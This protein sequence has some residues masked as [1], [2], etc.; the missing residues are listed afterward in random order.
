MFLTIMLLRRPTKTSLKMEDDFRDYEEHKEKLLQEDYKSKTS[1]NMNPSAFM[2]PGSQKLDQGLDMLQEESN[3]DLGTYLTPRRDRPDS[4]NEDD[5]IHR[6]NEYIN[7][8]LNNILP[9]KRREP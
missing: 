3:N 2:T 5:Q 8:L 7:N 9:D 6:S 4:G 1:L